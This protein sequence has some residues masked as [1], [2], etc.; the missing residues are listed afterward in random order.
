[1]STGIDF[2]FCPICGVSTVGQKNKS[3]Q[4]AQVWENDEPKEIKPKTAVSQ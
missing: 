2:N 4:F 3:Y 1:M